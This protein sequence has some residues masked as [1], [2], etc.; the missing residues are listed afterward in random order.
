MKAP[1]I[2]FSGWYRWND[3]MNIPCGKQRGVYIIARIKDISQAAANPEAKEI[4]Y[5]GET[6]GRNQ[7]I[8]KRLHKFFRAAQ[9]GGNL[10]KHSGGNRYNKCFQGNLDDI[11]AAAFAPEIKEPYLTPYIYLVERQLIW[12]YVKRWGRMPECNGK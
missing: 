1:P 2:Q 9:T 4:L 3:I 5:I 6:H 7:T 8:S 10:I 11:Y 12:A